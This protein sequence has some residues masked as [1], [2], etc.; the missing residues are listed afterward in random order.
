MGNKY[1]NLRVEG[2]SEKDARNR[3]ISDALGA[4]KETVI[5]TNVTEFKY[6]REGN[7]II[8]KTGQPVVKRVKMG[9]RFG[10]GEMKVAGGARET[11]TAKRARLKDAGSKKV[12]DNTGH[13][14]CGNIGCRQCNPTQN[15]RLVTQK[16][17]GVRTGLAPLRTGNPQAR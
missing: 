15:M 2:S 16:R 5:E 14:S 4:N 6:D 13:R 3:A 11:Q 8:D 17:G 9:K 1:E 12:R 7:V 10:M